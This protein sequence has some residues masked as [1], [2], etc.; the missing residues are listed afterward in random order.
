MRG[1]GL[2]PNRPAARGVVAPNATPILIS[3]IRAGS[4]PSRTDGR[5]HRGSTQALAAIVFGS[6]AKMVAAF[7]WEVG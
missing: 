4:T 7:F 5:L 3:Q 2:S 6:Y 1:R